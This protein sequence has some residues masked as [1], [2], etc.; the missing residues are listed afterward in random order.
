L[1]QWLEYGSETVIQELNHTGKTLHELLVEH[2]NANREHIQQNF[3]AQLHEVINTQIGI[4][5][6]SARADHHL[7]WSHYADSH[8]GVAVVFNGSHPFFSDVRKVDYVVKKS[9]LSFHDL[10]ESEDK[11]KAIAL[12]MIFAKHEDWSYEQE[13]RMVRPLMLAN[14][15]AGPDSNG[16]PVHLFSFPTECVL[17]VILGSRISPSDTE[18]FEKRIESIEYRHLQ[19][20]KAT[21][22]LE[23]LRID[24]G[25]GNAL[26]SGS[27]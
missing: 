17:G 24:V 3:V 2:S 25:D 1:E 26:S 21:T 7:L 11:G 8:R 19:I 27:T 5:S 16:Y 15:V 18:W 22:D 6:L 9:P 12:E 20:M 10:L 23:K 4:L 14:H 13:Y